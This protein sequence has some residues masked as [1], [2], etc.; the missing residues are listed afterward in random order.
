MH[1]CPGDHRHHCRKAPESLGR[2][3]FEQGLPAAEMPVRRRR[4]DPDLPRQ[5]AQA[6]AVGALL[7]EHFQRRLEQGAL[8]VAVMIAGLGA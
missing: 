3:R 5:L 8:Q 1:E 7:V 2:H 4:R 6:H